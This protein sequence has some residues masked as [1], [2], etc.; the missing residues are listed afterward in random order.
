MGG[1]GKPRTQA[2]PTAPAV[3]SRLSQC[4]LSVQLFRAGQFFFRLNQTPRCFFGTFLQP[5]GSSIW[6]GAAGTDSSFFQRAGKNPSRPRTKKTEG[7]KPGYIFPSPAP[8]NQYPFEKL[9]PA[10]CWTPPNRWVCRPGVL[11]QRSHGFFTL[12]AGRDSAAASHVFSCIVSLQKLQTFFQIWF[13]FK[14]LAR[15]LEPATGQH[16][17]NWRKNERKVTTKCGTK[18]EGKK[19]KSRTVP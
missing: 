13:P 10:T 19:E 14:M 6:H 11:V 16:R 2:P 9:T 4:S 8:E 1:A 3:P 12:S 7:E 17:Q 5:I 15:I 18:N